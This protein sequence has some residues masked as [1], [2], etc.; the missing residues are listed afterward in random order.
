MPM[1]KKYVKCERDTL[2]LMPPDM[3]EWIPKKDLAWFVVDLVKKLDLRAFHAKHPNLG[4]GRAAYDPEMM[5][6]LLIYAYC[7]GVRSSREIERLCVVNVAFRIIAGNNSPDHST[8]ARFRADFQEE[9]AAFFLRGLQLCVEAGMGKLGVVSLDG[10][11][12]AASASKSAT[13]SRSQIEVEV[14]KILEEAEE[15]DAEEDRLYGDKRGDELP[16]ELANP[17]S[18]LE[19]LEEAAR[20]LDERR[21]KELQDERD[22]LVEKTEKIIETAKRARNITTD[23]PRHRKRQRSVPQAEADLQVAEA[24]K[25]AVTEHRE[26]IEERSRSAGRKAPPSTRPDLER[27]VAYAR[28]QLDRAVA[29]EQ[30][31][32][33]KVRINITDLDS[34]SMKA[35]DGFLQGYNAQLVVSEDQIILAAEATTSPGDGALFVPMMKVLKTNLDESGIGKEVGVVLADAGYMSEDAATSPGPD[36]L[37]ATRRAW[38]LKRELRE[39]GYRSGEAPPDATVHEAMEHRLLTKE[40][41]ELYKKRCQTVEPVIGQIKEIQGLRRFMRRGRKAADSE[42]KF[43]AFTHN[44]LKH[45]RHTLMPAAQGA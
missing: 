17:G 36:R 13:K 14:K 38:K 19:R 10:T 15:I 11:K 2:Y 8:I 21:A 43:I 40:G 12:I 28:Q 41:T 26:E 6:A 33:A 44:V 5:L 18:R 3:R 32:A 23:N 31:E 45:Y 42:L 1:A 9:I 34:S 29:I 22:A 30:E 16:P 39:S 37:I 27:G 24:E 20:R 4:A 35:P 7:N 25:K